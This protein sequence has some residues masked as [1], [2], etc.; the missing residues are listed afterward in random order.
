[1]P[2]SSSF[3]CKT[4]AEIGIKKKPVRKIE[5]LRQK[6]KPKKRGGKREM[7]CVVK[8]P[9]QEDEHQGEGGGGVSKVVSSRE[10]FSKLLN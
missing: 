8:S 10:S 6:C 7:R 2:A 9:C 4:K 5:K 1:M 3:C